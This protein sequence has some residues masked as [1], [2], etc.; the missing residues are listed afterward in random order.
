MTRQHVETM[1]EP[2]YISFAT[3]DYDAH[4]RRLVE[5]LDRFG[6]PHWVS[7]MPG[8]GSWVRNCAMKPEFVLRMMRR[9][10][11]RPVVWVDADAVVRKYPALFGGL[12][13]EADAAVC[14]YAW[15]RARKTE[16]L[17]GTL[18]FENNGPSLALVGRWADLQKQAPDVWDQRTLEEALATTPEARVRNLPVEYCY[19][20][21]FHRD[22]NPGM[23]PVIEHF[24]ASRIA[25]Q[26]AP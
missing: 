9:H 23:E 14:K 17:S 1:T 15:K 3:P 20:T 25:R 2:L 10:P 12:G 16:V 21:D 18:Y 7:L 4:A 22:E 13:V 8:T 24:Q 5:S 11:D 19:I 26:K 6:L